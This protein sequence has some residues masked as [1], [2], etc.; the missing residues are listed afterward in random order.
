MAELFAGP[1]Q[2]GWIRADLDLVVYVGWMFGIF[3]GRTLI[4]IQGDAVDGD[5]LEPLHP[6]GHVHG[7]VRRAARRTDRRP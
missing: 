1:Q 3:L 4:D 5:G 2:K 6:R 7:P